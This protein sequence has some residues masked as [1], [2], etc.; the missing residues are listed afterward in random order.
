MFEINQQISSAIAIRVDYWKKKHKK[1]PGSLSAYFL[2]PYLQHCSGR[3]CK[4]KNEE[5]PHSSFFW[6]SSL[7][8]SIR[9]NHITKH[10]GQPHCVHFWRQ[11][12]LSLSGSGV[13]LEPFAHVRQVSAREWK[14]LLS[15]VLLRPASAN[16]VIV[17]VLQYLNTLA[18]LAI[19][20]DH[21][22]NW[23]VKCIWC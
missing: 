16:L 9:S 3:E 15:K 20:T 5:Q 17:S 1:A 19:T 8:K 6:R 4:R 13:R 21:I 14:E 22:S 11:L 23:S 18:S 2:A 7:Q 10:Q 12:S